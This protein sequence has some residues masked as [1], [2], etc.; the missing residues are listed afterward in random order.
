MEELT[1]AEV[2]AQIWCEPKNS[3]KIMDVD[4]ANSFIR[5]LKIEQA[6]TVGWE[7]IAN[8]NCRNQEFYKGLL[9]DIA[10]LI[11]EEAYI[12]E[13]G[14]ISSSVLITKLPDLVA[15]LINSQSNDIR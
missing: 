11:G 6:R 13:D 1:A 8:Q 7:T 5:I 10:L 3:Q 2:V 15:K 14:N 4:L 9:L 12:T